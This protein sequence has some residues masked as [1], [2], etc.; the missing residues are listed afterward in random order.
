[1]LHILWILIALLA[2]MLAGLHPVTVNNHL[3]RLRA[4]LHFL[5]DAGT[6]VCA[7]MLLVP[8]IQ[9]GLR[10]PVGRLN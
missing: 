2:S 3:F 7:R 6:L 5:D 8:P 4:F 10:L 9:S 1:M